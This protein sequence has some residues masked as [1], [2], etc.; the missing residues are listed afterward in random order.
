[1]SNEGGSGRTGRLLGEGRLARLGLGAAAVGGM[2]FFTTGLRDPYSLPKLMAITAGACAAWL[3]ICLD[4][5]S[6]GGARRTPL[7]LP[8]GAC[9]AAM[10]LSTF[11]SL[12][13]AV[14]VLGQYHSYSHG[15]LAFLVCGALFYAAAASGG[16]RGIF[17]A[18]T[19]AGALLGL[20]AAL[21]RAG[22][23]PFGGV[24]TALPG[25]RAFSASGSP[26]YLGAAL[27]FVCPAA[28]HL[29]LTGRGADRVLGWAGGV[30]CGAGLFLSMSRSGWLGAAVGCAAYW[31]LSGRLGRRRW[32]PAAA[33]CAAVLAAAGIGFLRPHAAADSVRIGT[34]RI[35]GR[36]FMARPLAGNGPD[37][38][39]LT[40]RRHR[41]DDMV[42]SLG[43]LRGQDNAHNDLVQAA[44]TTGLAG[45]G[46]Y[47][48]LLVALV[49]MLRTA[50]SED[51][52]RE[53]ASVVAGS[54]LGA[55]VQAKFNP[56]PLP[57]LALAAIWAG[58]A[59]PKS[60]DPEGGSRS[61][62]ARTHAPGAALCLC[63]FCAL[64]AF[65]MCRADRLQK[66]GVRARSAGDLSR[67]A[68]LFERACSIN[69]A[70]LRY[71]SA[72][73]RL[74]LARAEKR[75]DP[76]SRAGDLIRAVELGERAAAWHPEDPSAL[77]MLG[78]S[79]L[80]VK[81]WGGPDRVELAA[82]VLDKAGRL[83]PYFL[84]LIRARALAAEMRG[85]SAERDRLRSEHDRVKRLLP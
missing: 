26:V 55:F 60:P 10:A 12:D 85:N 67:A 32:V 43:D 21:Q 14:S 38:M 52:R 77:Q 6:G 23:E 31:A 1:M 56:V 15:L 53:E 8:L 69:P 24:L 73:N 5:R 35:A 27:L 65:Q 75:E 59:V 29:A 34:W 19:A 45:L 70:E 68:R 61:A 46:A 66:L 64:A 44:A 58:L 71:M 79:L 42:R 82:R 7:D 40:F 22:M 11:F 16:A 39:M 48:W 80:M 2:L 83:D 47:L 20:Y 84:P 33:L 25:G 63:L 57:V 54:L 3:G 62:S 72:Y 17:R 76:R 9:L 36:A 37:T 49:M 50:L 30:L 41:S 18:C 4:G 13:R 81:K 51:A 78:V 74:L 28:L